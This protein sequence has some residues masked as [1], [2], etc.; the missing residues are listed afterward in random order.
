MNRKAIIAIITLMSIAL[1]GI[2]LIQIYWI[3]F[4]INQEE[5]QF[6]NQ[7][8][9]ALVRVSEILSEEEEARGFS[10]FLGSNS[11]LSSLQNKEKINL[12]DKGNVAEIEGSLGNLKANQGPGVEGGTGISNYYQIQINRE[13]QANRHYLNSIKIEERI[14]PEKLNI[15]LEQELENSGINTE[16]HYGVFSNED[17]SFVIKDGHFVPVFETNPRVT[18]TEL[19]DDLYVTKHKVNLFTGS[20]KSPGSL[21]IAFPRIRNFLWR[22]VLQSVLASFLFTGLILFC[23]SYTIFVILRQKQVSEMKTDFINNMTHEFKTPIATISLAADSI[24]SPSILN[25][26]DKVQ[27]FTSIIKQENK[28]MLSQVEKVLQMALLDK[29]DFNL[30]LTDLDLHEIIFQAA[31]HTEL[32][33]QK[34]DGTLKTNLQADD[35]MIKGDVTHI[36]NVIHNLLDNANKYS[37]EKPEIIITTNNTANGI[38]VSIRDKGIGMSKEARKHIFDKFY[39]V[40]TGNIHDVKGF[41][42]GLSYVKAIVMAHKGNIEVESELGK[43]SNFILHFVKDPGH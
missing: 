4:S 41:G 31:N 30:K 42:L 40:H 38:S 12:I 29:K 6:N 14:D 28:R 20:V 7:V 24:N 34:K 5:N 1:L 35:S 2:V 39:R 17:S 3:N 15:I 9:V 26:P 23:F 27:R 13:K 43:G 18:N 10:P 21:H 19:S 11:S 8:Q 37:G 32:Q 16:Y 36:S 25:K 22:G 33:V